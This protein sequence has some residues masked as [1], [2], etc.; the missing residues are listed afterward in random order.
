MLT[1]IKPKLKTTTLLLLVGVVGFVE[2]LTM[3]A[4]DYFRV[5]DPLATGI[6]TVIMSITAYL[7]GRYLLLKPALRIVND[8]NIAV[9]SAMAEGLVFQDQKG[10][11]G[12]YNESALKVLGLTA[13]QLVGRTSMDP[14]WNAV[15]SD[16]T[17]FPGDEHPAMMA[18]ATGISQFNKVMGLNLPDGTFRW[19]KINAIP[20]FENSKKKATSVVCTF[21]DITVEQESLKEL[22]AASDRMKIAANAVRFGIWDW[23]LK[24]G[25]LVWDPLMYEIF[26]INKSDFTGDYD[27]FEKTLLPEDAITL[28]NKLQSN[29]A[30]HEAD[31]KDYFRINT[32]N[33]KIKYIA[34]AAK[35]IYDDQGNIDKMIG[36]NWDITKEKETEIEIS[37]LMGW[38]TS[39]LNSAGLMFIATDL[40][41][42]IQFF[43]HGA[44]HFLKYKACEVVDRETPALWHDA[45]EILDKAQRL[46]LQYGVEIKPNFEVFIHVPKLKGSETSNWTLIK[47]DGT[48]FP[49]KLTSSPMYNTKNEIIGY[50]GVL[51]DL[52]QELEMKHLIE[53]QQVQLASQLKM[54]SLGEM[55]SGIAHEINNPLTIILGRSQQALK[56][57]EVGDLDPIKTK[58]NLE[59][60]SSTTDRIAKIVSGLHSFS[61]NSN[62]DPMI[63]KSINKI[64]EE[65]LALCSEKFK[66]NGVDLKVMAEF[67][68]LVNCRPA[69]LSQVIL[70]LLNNAFDAIVKNEE[71]WVK[72]ELQDKKENG[73]VI[74]ITDSGKGIP[75]AIAEKIMQPFF[76]TK[77]IGKGTGLGLSIS[78]G[79]IEAHN[80]TLSINSLSPNTQFIIKLPHPNFVK[81]TGAA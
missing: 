73:F 33:N 10:V 12:F 18:L 50:L 63:L 70:N 59:V 52:S 67:D 47:K 74:I 30:A 61:R 11:I 21:S 35:C 57:L 56:A 14:Q 68:G 60:I 13:D 71:K 76:T 64:I 42:K 75:T 4:L 32:K 65:T 16:L 48:R 17:P 36:Y 25:V 3:I 41:G 38:Q 58:K 7:A 72:I 81:T 55:A 53:K 31:F 39:I 46:S 26:D 8:Q 79:I 1:F 22:K 20:Q 45:N 34:V 69:Q 29:F 6:D 78:K 66:F 23:N 51:E 43:N 80:G 28:Q 37:K 5:Q 27:A 40:D 44:E 49:A 9:F 54:A 77:E 19:I 62:K 24:T 15:K 2:F